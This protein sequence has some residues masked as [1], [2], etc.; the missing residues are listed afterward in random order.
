MYFCSPVVSIPVTNALSRMK[1]LLIGSAHFSAYGSFRRQ[2]DPKN[3]DTGHR[4]TTTFTISHPQRT[5]VR[6]AS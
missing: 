1:L 3:E 2:P 4:S 5:V 6:L